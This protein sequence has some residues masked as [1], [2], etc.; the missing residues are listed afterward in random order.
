MFHNTRHAGQR[1]DKLSSVQAW[2]F[3]LMAQHDFLIFPIKLYGLSAH[4]LYIL[5]R[6]YP[7]SALILLSQILENG[8]RDMPFLS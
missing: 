7:K 4:F 1:Q 3:R 5:A 8:E 6:F 2:L